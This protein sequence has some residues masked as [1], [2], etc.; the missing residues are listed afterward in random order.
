MLARTGISIVIPNYNGAQLLEQNLPSILAALAHWGG[1]FELIVVDDHSTDSSCQLLKERFPQVH[2]LVN[3]SNLGFSK[4]CNRGFTIAQYPIGICI[5]NDVKVSV[6][7]IAPLLDHFVEED[8][9]AVT[10]NILAE[11][12]DQNQGI[13]HGLYG[14]GFLKGSFARLEERG[15]VQ[16]N[17]YAI[18]ACV[19][20]DLV[21]FRAL[22]GYAEIYSPY[23]FEDVDISYRAW[24][25]GWKSLSEPGTTVWHYS[26]ATIGKTKKRQ[27]RTIYF[28]NRFLFHWSNLS[29]PAFILRN[30]LFTFFRLSVS[31]LWCNFTYYSAFWGALRCWRAV[32]VGRR[33]EHPFRKFGDAEIVRRTASGRTHV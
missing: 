23:L 21:K 13:V 1:E 6:D 30:V 8:V 24:K 27:K 7:F 15:T 5:N 10:P 12:D 25:R 17:F 4:T 11:R 32:V 16:E 29:D 33:A 2:L 22:G 20:Y 18:G 3:S 28:R 14:K 26:S 31:F 19:A 9:F